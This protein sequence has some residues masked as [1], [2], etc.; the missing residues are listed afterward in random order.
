[1]SIMG[2][3]R[4]PRRAQQGTCTRF[5]YGPDS[6]YARTQ[7]E[8]ERH[9]GYLSNLPLVGSFSHGVAEARLP[10]GFDTVCS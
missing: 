7:S 5:M 9:S 4:T 10:A 6:P 8:R 1:M 3:R 2:R